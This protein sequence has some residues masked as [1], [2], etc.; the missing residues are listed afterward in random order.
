MA[1]GIDLTVAKSNVAGRITAGVVI[2]AILGW[3]ITGSGDYAFQIASFALTLLV[4]AVG[5]NLV[6]GVMGY[7]SLG[8]TAFFGLGAYVA[9]LSH[10]AGISFV[11]SILLGGV[12]SA[13]AALLLGFTALRLTR[14]AFAIVTLV[15]LL[16][17][18]TAALFWS[19][20]T[21]GARGLP[22][23]V[24]PPAL[25]AFLGDLSEPTRLY[26]V[27][28]AV[29]TVLIAVM[30]FAMTSDWGG[31]LRLIR[32]DEGLAMAVGVNVIKHK[33]IAFAFAGMTAGVIGALHAYRVT[34]VDP[35]VFAVNL[36]TPVI[37][38]VML[39]GPGHYGSVIVVGYLV[40]ILPDVFR[41]ANAGR[42]VIF[43]LILMLGGLLLPE[44]LPSL[45]QRIRQ[46][47]TGGRLSRVE[48]TPGTGDD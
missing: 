9:A 18:G 42:F 17:L 14:Y 24:P 6:F 40:G 5:L 31:T 34:F 43:G 39:G 23:I 10:N 22:N 2:I 3:P 35:S 26:I 33:V 4:L 47:G 19:D 16:G 27:I 48:P 32:Q 15:M 21:R 25:L 20:V 28:A 12:V 29:A 46:R 45:Y 41:F 44:G 30:H 13:A 8:Q 36:A 1:T 11:V 7:M 38:M 37:A